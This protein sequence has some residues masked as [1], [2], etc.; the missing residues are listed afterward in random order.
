[1]L[2]KIR[3]L[4]SWYLSQDVRTQRMLAWGSAA[5]FTAMVYFYF[6]GMIYVSTDDAFVDGHVVA[7][8][9]K[10]AAHASKV[11]IDDN[12]EVKAGELLVELDVRDFAVHLDMAKAALE[13]AEA[14]ARY[15]RKDAE[16]YLKLTETDEIS[17][18]QSEMAVL[19]SEMADARVDQAKA[20]VEQAELQVSYTKI[21][22]P[23]AG[24][25]TRK[26]VEAGAY[27]QPGQPLLAIVTHDKWVV[28]NF[29]ETQIKRMRTGQK[30]KVK[31]D[32]FPGKIFRGHVDSVQ[33]GTGARFSLFPPE[34]AT[35]N[36]VKVV[37]RVPVKI[38]FDE[39]QDS[40]HPLA[41]GMSVIPEVKVR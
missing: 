34:N 12:Q 37:Q 32:T 23:S 6:H 16:R 33:R 14:E 5:V 40:A 20:Q 36:F 31:V 35:G 28:A 25:V 24:H 41:V 13:S 17:K 4:K 29:K 3:A 8:S 15:A 21:Y 26:S 38:V 11:Y 10:V 19:R 22:A 2:T 27:V 18:Q 30:V 7:V 39:S 9:P 1:M